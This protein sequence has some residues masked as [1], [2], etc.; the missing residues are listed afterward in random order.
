L[1]T[2]KAAEEMGLSEPE[3]TTLCQHG[4]PRLSELLRLAECLCVP[5]TYFLGT[6]TQDGAF[7][8]VGIGNIQKIKIG[9]A[10]AHQLAA[11]LGAKVFIMPRQTLLSQ[12]QLMKENSKAIPDAL[13][14]WHI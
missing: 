9:K 1:L 8:Q 13:L 7:N 4:D 12:S 2:S 5:P 3:L 11:Q 14:L 10:A 6:I